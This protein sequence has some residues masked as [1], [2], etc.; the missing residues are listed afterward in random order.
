MRLPDLV[1]KS[2][3][4]IPRRKVY[5][6]LVVLRIH[7]PHHHLLPL[8]P[9]HQEARHEHALEGMLTKYDKIL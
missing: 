6:S 4:V 1:E 2:G 3:A 5:D 7:M 9:S 8:C